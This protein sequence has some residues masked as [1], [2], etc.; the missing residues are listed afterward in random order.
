M[1]RRLIAS[2]AVILITAVAVSPVLAQVLD[3]EA[4]LRQRLRI[5]Q[6]FGFGDN[7]GLEVPSE[8]RTS[9]ATTRLSYGLESKTRT[10]ELSFAIGAA[11]RFGD[12]AE[13]NNIQTGFTDP[14]MA[15]RYKRDAAN[16]SISVDADYRQSDISLGIPLWTF[17]DQDGLV[18]P[19]RDFSNI[20]GSG[21]RRG[22]NLDVELETGKQANIGFRFL[23]AANGVNYIDATDDLLNDFDTTSL[24][25]STLFRFDTVTTGVLDLRY[26]TFD[27]KDSVD[28]DRVTE[29]IE[30]GFDRELSAT[31]RLTFRAGYT[32]VDTTETN[33]LNGQRFSTKRSGPSGSFGF[34]RDLTN[35]SV[36]ATFDLTQD[37]DGQRG[38]LQFSRSLDLRTGSLRANI[39]LTSVDS[40]DPRVIGGLYWTRDFAASRLTLRYDRDVFVDSN[41]DDRFSDI[42]IAGYQIDINSVSNLTADLSLTKSE[43]SESSEASQRGN[44]IVTYS[45]RLT[46]DWSLNTGVEVNFLDE[47]ISGRAESSAIFFGIGRNFDF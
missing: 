39:G 1:N 25:V 18:R 2:T 17:L 21:E 33:L 19:P 8:G 45:H 46:Q 41:D 40:T 47:D 32:D 44:L 30:V 38:T 4:S 20:R 11:L 15:L 3:D 31:S 35:G 13:G 16:A 6:E 28:T 22:Y 43:A 14:F 7:L 9:L 5:E 23:A 12:V 36:D 27:A 10:Q 37:Q 29:T 34:F 26:E 24:G 42:L